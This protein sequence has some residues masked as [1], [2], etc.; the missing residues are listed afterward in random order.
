MIYLLTFFAGAFVGMLITAC[1]AISKMNSIQDEC[2][3]K[4]VLKE[5]C[6]EKRSV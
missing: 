2:Y 4:Y 3:K 6:G 5:L 1:L